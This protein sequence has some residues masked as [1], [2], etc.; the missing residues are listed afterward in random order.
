VLSLVKGV[1]VYIFTWMI[2]GAPLLL[3]SGFF[4]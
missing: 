2:D 3:T 4:F 1:S